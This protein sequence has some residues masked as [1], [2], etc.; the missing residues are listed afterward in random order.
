[1]FQEDVKEVGSTSHTKINMLRYTFQKN[2]KEINSI[3]M[4]E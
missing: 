1:M 2:V 4:T 3:L